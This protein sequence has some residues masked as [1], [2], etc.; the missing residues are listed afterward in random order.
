MSITERIQE[1]MRTAMKAGDRKRATALRM[2]LS[3]LHMGQKEAAG[4][5]GEQEELRVLA[6]E[7][8][9]RNQA[10]E[11]FREGGREESARDEEAEAELISS[12]L[13]EALGDEELAEII[14]EAI[15]STGAEGIKDMG[16]V[17]SAVMS[18]AGGRADGKL[19]SEKVK[20]VL[21]G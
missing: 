3:Q 13:P 6:A 5:F 8:K 20:E 10:A 14:D 21:S 19:V 4:E 1:D 11:A 2:L 9:R 15:S 7:K 18:K 16:K 17:M 12:Y